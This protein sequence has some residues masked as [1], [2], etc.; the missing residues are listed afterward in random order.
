MSTVHVPSPD[1]KS[2]LKT[3]AENGHGVAVGLGVGVGVGVGV[4]DGLGVGVAALQSN[5]TVSTLQPVPP[6]LVSLPALQRS[7]MTLPFAAAGN[8]TVVVI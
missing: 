6:L 4:G 2:W 7:W 1:S 8:C 3:V 5:V